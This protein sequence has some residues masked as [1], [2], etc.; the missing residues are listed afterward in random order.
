MMWR[1]SAN[2][3]EDGKLSVKL[4]KKLLEDQLPQLNPTWTQLNLKPRLPNGNKP[5]SLETSG[6]GPQLSN[7]MTQFMASTMTQLLNST[8]MV[9]E[10]NGPNKRLSNGTTNPKPEWFL[11]RKKQFPRNP[12]RTNGYLIEMLISNQIS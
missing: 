11:F 5:T 8:T 12:N 6:T 9:K 4:D 10:D 7:T 1:I 2:P 3:W